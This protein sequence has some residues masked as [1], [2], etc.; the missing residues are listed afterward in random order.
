MVDDVTFFAKRN[1]HLNND[2]Q[3]LLLSKY[4]DLKT[5]LYLLV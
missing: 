3:Q 2:L 1:I 4:V 5:L